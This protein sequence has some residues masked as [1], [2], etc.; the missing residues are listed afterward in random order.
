M[1]MLKDRLEIEEDIPQAYLAPPH[2]QLESTSGTHI[3]VE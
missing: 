3:E 2:S 1:D